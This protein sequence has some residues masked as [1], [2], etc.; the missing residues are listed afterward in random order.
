MTEDEMVGWHHRFNGHEFGWTPGAGDGQGGLVCCSPRGCR[1]GHDWATEQQ[2]HNLPMDGSVTGCRNSSQW[3]FSYLIK[4]LFPPHPPALNFLTFIWGYPETYVPLPSHS[5][6]WQQT[7][8][9]DAWN[10]AFTRCVK[11]EAAFKNTIIHAP[12]LTCWKG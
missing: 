5:S 2:Q 3:G 10:V 4:R 11:L 7:S 9:I 8:T 6:R 1:V 12:F